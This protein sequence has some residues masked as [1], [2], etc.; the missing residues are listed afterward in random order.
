VAL[1]VHDCTAM[2]PSEI[3]HLSQNHREL[4]ALLDFHNRWL[5][6][7]TAI[8][9]LGIFAETIAEFWCSKDKPR[10]EVVL[11]VICSLF[12]LGGVIG[13]YI[14]SGNVAGKA[15]EL[16]QMADADVGSLDGQ[17]SDASERAAAAVRDSSRAVARASEAE[18]Q[19]AEANARAAEAV[20]KADQF[21]LQIADAQREAATTK[22]QEAKV[23]RLLGGNLELD[24]DSS[25]LKLK[26]F[27][28]TP[29]F[30]KTTPPNVAMLVLRQ[31]GESTRW[32]AALGFA[33]TF[34]RLKYLPDGNSTV[35]PMI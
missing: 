17:A 14:E 8:V 30:V 9:A 21:R 1:A 11:T 10:R 16:Q 15:R 27:A 34:K 2:T 33:E 26:A 25:L 4:E 5:G 12:V 19:L 29:C 31:P 20:V 22:L 24:W 35:F 3:S 18:S 7:F 28:G 23:E 6:I 13:E 32:L